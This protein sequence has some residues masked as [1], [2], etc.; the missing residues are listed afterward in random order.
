MSIKSL[1][2]KIGAISDGAFGPK[3]IKVAEQI[4]SYVKNKLNNYLT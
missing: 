1:Q 3:T 2:T 4:V